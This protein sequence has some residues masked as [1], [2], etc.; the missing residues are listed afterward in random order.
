MDSAW[1]DAHTDKQDNRD[2]TS[3]ILVNHY[4]NSLT[5]VYKFIND[6]H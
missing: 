5:H 6:D 1:A 4:L 2:S 3:T